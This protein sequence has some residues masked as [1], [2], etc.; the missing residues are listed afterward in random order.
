MSD[1]FVG[2]VIAVAFDFAPVGWLPC[3]GSLVSIGAHQ[4]LYALIGT[5]YGG[6]GTSTFGLPDLRGR[7]VVGSGQAPGMQDYTIGMV[8]GTENV[9]ITAAQIAAHSHGIMAGA[10][11]STDVP[12]SNTVL[13]TPASGQPFVYRP[14]TGDT[15]LAY[16]TMTEQSG[17]PGGPHEN[18]QPFQAVRYIIAV[19]GIFPSRP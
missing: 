18:R 5:T 2:Q 17:S 15:T 7:Q 16:G 10:D 13:G 19:N 1:P 3:D 4:A 11:G 14:G 6:D 8:A 12:A 9:T